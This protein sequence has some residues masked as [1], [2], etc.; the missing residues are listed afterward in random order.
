MRVIPVERPIMVK[1]DVHIAAIY[2]HSKEHLFRNTIMSFTS[3]DDD[4]IVD[5]KN[6]SFR[7]VVVKGNAAIVIASEQMV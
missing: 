3:R 6:R 2:I 1:R 4:V 5:E 7:E